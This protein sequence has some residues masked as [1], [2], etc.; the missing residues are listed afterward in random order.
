MRI[1]IAVGLVLLSLTS[2]GVVVLIATFGSVEPDTLWFE[3]A[4]TL[5]Q[6][7][8]VLVLGALLSLMT[9][10]YQRRQQQADSRRELLSD[11]L[12]RAARAYNDVKRARRLLRGQATTQDGTEILAAPYDQQTA[13]INDAQLEFETLAD[14]VR[15]AGIPELA[16][17][18]ATK[19][20]I[21]EKSLGALVTEY[22]TARREFA[23]DPLSLQIARLPVLESFLQHPAKD[24]AA[25]RVVPE[26]GFAP[27]HN[28]FTA[29][30]RMAWRQL[31]RAS[32]PDRTG[33]RPP[34]RR[35]AVGDVANKDS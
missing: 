27:V 20:D 8:V 11:L 12:G 6:V 32:P 1:K 17:S 5:L 13:A 4:K 16:E 22:E 9:T 26:P 23:G 24:E 31:L 3:I 28:A 14:E 10:E 34:R 25:P 2:L 29:A 15:G 21:I 35:L 7:G 19:F 30:Q 18:L 33:T